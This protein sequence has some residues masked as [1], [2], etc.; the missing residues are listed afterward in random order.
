MK[1]FERLALMFAVVVLTIAMWRG[2]ATDQAM[3]QYRGDSKPV[4]TWEQASG[5]YPDVSGAAQPVCM[6]TI[7]LVLPDRMEV[8]N[9]VAAGLLA[10][11]TW[12]NPYWNEGTPGNLISHF[13]QQYTDEEAW[14][15]ADA[16]AAERIVVIADALIEAAG[17]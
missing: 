16:M 1:Q 5:D 8:V 6:G 17:G 3:A 11:P 10:H 7:A 15:M 12:R 9:A 2:G 13:K 14:R 4:V